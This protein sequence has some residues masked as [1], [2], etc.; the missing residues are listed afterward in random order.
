[1]ERHEYLPAAGYL[2]ASV[3]VSILGLYAGLWLARA[4]GA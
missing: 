3:G 1:M 4:L 2:I